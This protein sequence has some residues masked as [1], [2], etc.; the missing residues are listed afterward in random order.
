MLE[1]LVDGNRD[2]TGAEAGAED[3]AGPGLHRQALREALAR[4][5]STLQ[6]LIATDV[7]MYVG[8]YS[9]D[10]ANRL[11]MSD[12][13]IVP[14]CRTDKDIGEMARGRAAMMPS[15]AWKGGWFDMAPGV[16]CSCLSLSEMQSS[17]ES[18]SE[19]ESE[20]ESGSLSAA[21]GGG[22]RDEKAGA[23]VE[24]GS[25]SGSG[26]GRASDD[27]GGE[28]GPLDRLVLEPWDASPGSVPPGM[29]GGVDVL[30]CTC[31]GRTVRRWAESQSVD[32]REDAGGD[33]T[34]PDSAAVSRR[35][36]NVQVQSAVV[37]V[38]VHAGYRVRPTVWIPAIAPSHRTAIRI[39]PP[40]LSA[41]TKTKV[42]L[43]PLAYTYRGGGPT[44]IFDLVERLA[45]S[46]GYASD[47]SGGRSG[48]KALLNVASGALTDHKSK[49]GAAVA[50]I[51]AEWMISGGICLP[52][53]RNTTE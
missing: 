42:L 36:V 53:D 32:E 37:G 41:S 24:R 43:H 52:M 26:S 48:F 21:A 22:G 45:L 38:R 33:A 3:E 28:G 9:V 14:Y 11:L 51:L 46:R 34:S 19:S 2:G 44:D 29:A 15:G 31:V 50:G 5:Q 12:F 13:C 39:N 47:A 18:K 25:G 6:P 17:R 35:A 4:A 49:R 16:G 8:A 20:S 27:E 1:D 7:Q 23:G 30:G 10:R 40:A